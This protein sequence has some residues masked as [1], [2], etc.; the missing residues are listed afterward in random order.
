M[1]NE[2]LGNEQMRGHGWLHLWETF[3][4]F[5]GV[6]RVRVYGPSCDTTY[7]LCIT[8]R[9]SHPYTR[10]YPSPDISVCTT[11]AIS[12][13]CVCFLLLNRC[14]YGPNTFKVLIRITTLCL[15]AKREIIFLLQKQIL[16]NSVTS[17]STYSR[18]YCQH[19]CI[20]T[21]NLN[22]SQK[23]DFNFEMSSLFS[24]FRPH[25]RH[26]F[27]LYSHHFTFILEMQTLRINL[28]PGPNTFS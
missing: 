23:L 19:I 18:A 28:P 10:I 7:A 17:S 9:C 14:S 13:K 3:H 24:T 1:Q 4:L 20:K 26:V 8:C 15:W 22:Y 16:K 2:I 25:S 11:A 27:Q 21:G 12:S 6:R 5:A